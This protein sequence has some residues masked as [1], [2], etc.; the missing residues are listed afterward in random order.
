MFL[1][2]DKKGQSTLEYGILIAVIVGALI[3]MSV[4]MKRSLQGKFRSS[5]DDIG[6]QYSPSYTVSNYSTISVYGST[7]NTTAGVTTTTINYDTRGRSGT[8]T[9]EELANE[10][11]D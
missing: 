10:T 7:D 1:K 2:K 3:A 6:E 4:Y 8:E 5:A 11:W 9:I